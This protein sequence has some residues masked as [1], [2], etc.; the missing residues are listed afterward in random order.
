[1]AAFSDRP[2]AFSRA[3]AFHTITKIVVY[4]CLFFATAYVLG[5]LLYWLGGYIVSITATVL[6]AAAF[7]NSLCLRIYVRRGIAAIGLQG[8]RAALVNLGFGCLGGMAAAALV[9]AGPLLFHAARIAPDPGSPASVSSFFF[10]SVLLLFGSAG[11]ELLFRGFGFQV[12]LRALGGWTT[13]LPVGVIFAVMHAGNPNATWLGLANTAGFGILFGYAFLRSHD[14][15]LPIGV[16]FG[17]NFTL[18]L[19][20][21]NVSG[22]TMRLTGFTMR[23]SAGK[24]WSGGEYGPEASILTSAV[25]FLLFAYLW[26][27]PIRRQPSALLDPPAGDVTCAPGPPSSPPSR[28]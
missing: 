11:E 9:L 17:W 21:V 18:P 4:V 19:F 22:L 13:I 14:I 6:L 26:K 2:P 3:D 27:A 25:L 23:W 5:P 24:L 16:H 7:S 8:D 28:P 20:G 12:L 10:V 1:M 15:W